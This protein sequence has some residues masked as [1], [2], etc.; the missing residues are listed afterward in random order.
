MWE[1]QPPVEWICSD[2]ADGTLGPRLKWAPDNLTDVSAGRRKLLLGTTGAPRREP[3]AS[4][5]QARLGAA[6]W[7]VQ[8]SGKQEARLVA[9][10]ISHESTF[11]A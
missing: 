7:N 6:A 1:R 4:H 3:C 5:K 10:E 11:N 9:P 2:P 8:G